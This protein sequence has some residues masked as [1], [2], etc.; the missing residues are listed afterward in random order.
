[1]DYGDLVR[2]H[3]DKD[4]DVTVA[5]T[6]VPAQWA[7]SLGV[8]HTDGD[9]R[10]VGI[11]EKCAIPETVTG[12]CLVN[13]GVYVFR[14][15]VLA[16]LDPDSFP[17]LG[18][19]VIPELIRSGNAHT[20]RFDR[21]APH[22]YRYWIDIGTVDSYFAAHQDLLDGWIPFVTEG[23][24]RSGMT[25]KPRTPDWMEN[26]FFISPSAQLETSE[27]HRSVIGAGVWIGRN[28]HVSNSIILPGARIGEG[29][30]VQNSIVDEFASI[31][32][33]DAV[34]IDSSS[35]RC[36]HL[37]TDRGLVIVSRP[38]SNTRDDR[39]TPCGAN[40]VLV[41][42][43]DARYLQ[44]ARSLL[45]AEGHN[46]VVAHSLAKL[47]AVAR[48]EAPNIRVAVCGVFPGSPS[49][50]ALS[51]VSLDLGDAAI[52]ARDNS[53]A[54]DLSPRSGLPIFGILTEPVSSVQLVALVEE[55]LNKRTHKV[56]V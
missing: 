46:V 27:V 50:E 35:D 26:T 44:W 11:S 56:A 31:P 20:Y 13:M 38:E 24:V 49:H 39:H 30:I 54:V 36:R 1:M 19:H 52:V 8:V 33:G 7:S 32:D 15:E 29:A 14:P 12:P 16:A 37:V 47:K 4:A 6:L 25:S 22:N 43:G 2:C 41:A 45:E 23:S 9:D 21:R 18:P 53:D 34:G 5:T 28:A 3:R 10:L 42:D 17:E 55:A 48:R 51:V 40:A